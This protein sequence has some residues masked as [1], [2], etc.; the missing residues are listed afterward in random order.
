MTQSQKFHKLFEPT[1]NR[2]HD[3]VL[4]FLTASSS[5]I[6]VTTTTTTLNNLNNHN[7]DRD[8][9]HNNHTPSPESPPTHQNGDGS[10]RG[11]RHDMSQA[12]SMFFFLYY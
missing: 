1:L 10:T 2:S 11:S 9:G 6:T 8:D 5:A 3:Y 12:A 7:D 4:N